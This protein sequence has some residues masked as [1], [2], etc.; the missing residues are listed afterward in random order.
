MLGV[1]PCNCLGVEDA[2]AGIES[3]R[4]AG[5]WAVAIGEKD[6]FYQVKEVH[7]TIEDASPSIIRWLEGD[8]GEPHTK[9]R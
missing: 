5:M 4:A 1:L 9:E 8:Y 7:Q 3:I 6:S 2:L